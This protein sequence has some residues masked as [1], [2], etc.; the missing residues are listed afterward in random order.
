MTKQIVSINISHQ[1]GTKKEPVES[2][3]L[4]VDHGIEGDAHAGNWHRQISLLAIESVKE[5]EAKGIDLFSGDFGE[6]ITTE[7]LTLKD[8]PVG[9]Q[10]KMGETVV[11]EITQIGKVC[12]DKCE[13]YYQVGDCI[14]PKE[15]IFA[16]V[17]VGGSIQNGDSVEVVGPNNQV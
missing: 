6:N 13:I 15:G 3:V 7:G 14:M 16:K 11:L 1:K 17:I 12:H 10:L 2:A 5:M 9:S 8:I 4:R